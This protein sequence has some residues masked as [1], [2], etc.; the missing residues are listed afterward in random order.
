VIR[1]ELS[2]LFF[3]LF[4]KLFR[5]FHPTINIVPQQS[6]PD[7]LV[8]NRHRLGTVVWIQCL[9]KERM[10]DNTHVPP[11]MAVTFMLPL[12]SISMET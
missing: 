2:P 7:L 4:G 10:K 1:V 9:H 6:I 3:I 8:W 5:L 11:A 12:A